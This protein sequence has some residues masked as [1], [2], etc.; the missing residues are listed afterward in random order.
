MSDTWNDN[1]IQFPRLIAEI[2]ANVN[3]G[4]D[5][6]ADLRNSMDLNQWE[7]NELFDRAQAEWERIKDK[8]TKGETPCS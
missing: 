2:I 4:E 1:S 5:E 6:M 7:V 3:I 8:I